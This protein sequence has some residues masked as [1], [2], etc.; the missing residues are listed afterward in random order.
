MWPTNFKKIK[1]S[2]I[3]INIHEGPISIL[4][5]GGAD[6]AV[7][8]Y[9]LMTNTNETINVITC[10]NKIKGRTN[11]KIALD[12]IGTCIDITGNANITH[13][14]FFVEEQTFDSLFLNTKMLFQNSNIIYTGATSLPPDNL[15]RTFK[16]DAG[17]YDNRDPNKIRP[18]YRDK[19]YAPFFNH[20][21]IHIRQM[22]EELGIIEKIFPLTRSCESLVLREG[23]CGECWWCEERFWAFG[24][25]K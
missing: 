20:N 12:V 25:Y 24:R 1:I 3:N 6:S 19:F 17:I 14:S 16:N 18:L 7:L 5:S 15:L 9:I 23:H 10:S 11:S 8:L 13:S 2:G 21:K 4:H 22:Y